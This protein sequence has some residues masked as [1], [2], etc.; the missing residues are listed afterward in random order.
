MVVTSALCFAAS[1]FWGWPFVGAAP[2]LSIKSF[3]CKGRNAAETSVDVAIAVVEHHCV[4]ELV[5]I[6]LA[7]DI[8]LK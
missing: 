1:A 7:H 4:G 3:V 8:S 6:A 5:G 2:P